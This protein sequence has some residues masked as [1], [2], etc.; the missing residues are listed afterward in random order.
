VL[1]EHGSP[2]S[3]ASIINDER[4]HL[5]QMLARLP[6]LVAD[7]EPRLTLVMQEEER[8]F[9]LW[10]DAIEAELSPAAQPSASGAQH[11]L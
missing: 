10:L 1:V 3:V 6:T 8:E 11:A 2:V 7:W 5:E 4:D 9:C